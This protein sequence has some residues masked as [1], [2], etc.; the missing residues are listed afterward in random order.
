VLP[1][2]VSLEA[3]PEP[4]DE[5]VQLRQV[6]AAQWAVIRF[7]GR[8]NSKLEAQHLAT[9]R[10]TLSEAG[11]ATEGEPMLARYNPHIV[12]GFLHRNELWLA[13]KSP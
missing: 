1:R 2:A 5:R 12:P 10:A 6:P 11:L 4:L 8:W 9:L 13:L 7:S 3:A